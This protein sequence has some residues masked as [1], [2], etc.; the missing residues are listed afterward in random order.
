MSV[1]APATGVSTRSAVFTTAL[2]LQRGLPFLALPIVAR[3]V[4]QETFGIVAVVTTAAAVGAILLSLGLPGAV[5]RLIYDEGLTG[6]PT[7][8]VAMVRVQ[9]ATATT[10]LLLAVTVLALVEALGLAEISVYVY[11]VPLLALSL[12]VHSVFQ[13]IAVARGAAAR[14]L[15]AALVQVAVGAGLGPWSAFRLGGPAFVVSLAVASLLAAA[16]LSRPRLPPPR[17]AVARI[18]AGLRLA[19]PFVWQSVSTWLLSLSDRVILALYFS[20]GSVGVYQVSYMVGSGVG[21]VLEGVQS[22]W[23]PRYYRSRHP[24]KRAILLGL[25]PWFVAAGAA[26]AL[27][28]AV[29]SPLVLGV[30]APG[31]QVDLAVLG[32]V[33]LA[34][35]PRSAYFVLVADL[36]ERKLTR[37]IAVSTASGAALAVGLDLLVLPVTGLWLAAVA[38]VLAF[39]VQAL[40]VTRRA[41]GRGWSGAFLGWTVAPLVA[42]SVGL[43]L[44]L[45]V[46]ERGR[47]VELLL[48]GGVLV[49]LLAVTGRLLFG[50][51]QRATERWGADDPDGGDGRHEG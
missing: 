51:L 39:V 31:Y 2:V 41:L 14:S 32:I 1:R 34:G 12:S 27:V 49:A 22:A 20:L 47:T 48:T 45:L 15:V 7:S 37:S 5:P 36:L 50:R 38:T 11:L 8:W 46:A 26:A 6:A 19:V 30:V 17:W 35:V 29:V 28:V 16:V 42:T 23:A 9:M 10:V 44:C 24:G 43:G 18:R 33:A 40:I 13:G 3:A 21:L 4:S 25:V